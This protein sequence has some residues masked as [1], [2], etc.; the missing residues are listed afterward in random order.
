VPLE[1]LALQHALARRDPGARLRIRAR[2]AALLAR[3]R[4]FRLALRDAAVV[5]RRSA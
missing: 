1:P 4:V 2:V 3:T 5:G